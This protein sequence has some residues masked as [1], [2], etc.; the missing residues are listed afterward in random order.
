VAVAFRAVAEVKFQ[1]MR[2]KLPS[3]SVP[4]NTP[5]RR[6]QRRERFSQ[7][8]AN[9]RVRKGAV[10]GDNKVACIDSAVQPDT[11]KPRLIADD[12]Q[13]QRVIL[14][15]GSERFAVDITT[16]MRKLPPG[17]GDAPAPVLPLKKEPKGGKK[18]EM[19]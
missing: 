18:R 15:I 1:F 9:P 11:T 6:P 19:E 8:A 10:R 2:P 16:R 7:A 5:T 3:S 17:T 12:A 4:A 14:G 13:T